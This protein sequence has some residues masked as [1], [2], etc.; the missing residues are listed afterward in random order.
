M[1]RLKGTNRS[2]PNG[3]SIDGTACRGLDDVSRNRIESRE[4]LVDRHA[5]AGK[6]ANPVAAIGDGDLILGRID[7]H[8]RQRDL[9]FSAHIDLVHIA[10]VKVDVASP[11]S[12]LVVCGAI[13]RL[14]C[15]STIGSQCGYDSFFQLIKG[16][17]KV[18]R[19]PVLAFRQCLCF[20]NGYNFSGGECYSL[21]PFG[22]IAVANALHSH[23]IGGLGGKASEGVFSI[24]NSNWIVPSGY[25]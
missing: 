12:T 24:L 20:G 6:E 13:L 4:S 3:T 19:P 17:V 23:A 8:T 10:D 21:A 5:L 25:D 18:G 11:S 1:T 22:L 15:G 7:W 16:D 9:A 14:D 2:P